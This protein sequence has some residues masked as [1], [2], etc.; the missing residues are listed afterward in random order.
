MTEAQLHRAVAQFLRVALKPPQFF[1]TF[2]A[3]GGGR[4]RGAQLKAMGLAPGMPDILVFHTHMDVD[5]WRWPEVYGIELKTKKGEQSDT[6]IAMA[7]AFDDIGSGIDV[8]RS[9]EEVEKVLRDW[10]VPL[11]ATTMR[12]AA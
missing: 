4:V 1:T 9:V 8:C 7:L 6:Q 3:G 5:G 2:P 11:H 10:G 12:A